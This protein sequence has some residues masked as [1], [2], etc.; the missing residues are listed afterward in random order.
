[1]RCFPAGEE[2][3]WSSDPERS[4]VR[5]TVYFQSELTSRLDMWRSGLSGPFKAHVEQHKDPSGPQTQT[6]AFFIQ[7]P[8]AE[9]HIDM[10][11]SKAFYSPQHV[12]S[13]VLQ[14]LHMGPPQSC[15]NQQSE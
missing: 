11:T 12:G 15:I 4:S 3:D 2:Q 6:V 13:V 8:T 1:M 9:A 14:R 10:Q 5:E 7:D